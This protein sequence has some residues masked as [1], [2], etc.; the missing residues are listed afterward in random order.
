MRIPPNYGPRYTRAFEQVFAEAAESSGAALVPFL[1]E[2][3]AVDP[4]M[5][6]DDGIHPTAK[7]QPNLVEGFLPYLETMM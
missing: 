3:L 5:M 2:A 1:F 6:Q 4:E 7:A